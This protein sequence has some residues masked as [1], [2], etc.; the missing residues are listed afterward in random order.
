MSRKARIGVI[1]AGW[2]AA[3]VHLPNIAAHTHAELIGICDADIDRAN[4]AKEL[5]GASM[6]TSSYEE[7]LKQ[8]LDAVLVATPHNAH[9][10]PAKAALD[11]GADVLIEKPMTLDP[12]EAWELVAL[13]GSKKRN[14]H[15][16]YTFPHSSH[17][18]EVRQK[19]VT[20][21]IGAVRFATG[22]FTGN[23]APLY[24]GNVE[25]QAE[26]G[27]P[28]I[29]RATTYSAKSSGGGQLYTQTTHPVSTL[30]FMLDVEAKSVKGNLDTSGEVDQSNSLIF[31][32]ESQYICTV[33]SSGLMVDHNYR[34]EEYRVIGEEG[35]FQ[36]DTRSGTLISQRKGEEIKVHPQLTTEDANPIK[37]PSSS[38]ITTALGI[39]DVVASGELGAKTVDILDGCK[40]SSERGEKVDISRKN[41]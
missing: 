40:R 37:G 16:G 30:L 14:L 35:F 9:F 15:M 20:G 1:G 41:M 17:V 6:A 2:W 24:R 28:F 11:A 29:S 31:S 33:S 23:I 34:M 12:A 36:L 22:L 25:I 19:I 38:L 5:F 8:D 10:A 26:E 13:A 3:R 4:K 21:Y 32:D 18:Q 27:A 39:T 7:L